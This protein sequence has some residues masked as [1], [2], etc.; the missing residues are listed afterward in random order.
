MLVLTRRAGE[1][2]LINKGEVRIKVLCERNGTVALGVQVSA[3]MNVDRKEIFT[4]KMIQAK[5]KQGF[6]DLEPVASLPS[7]FNNLNLRNKPC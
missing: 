4:K 3:H 6:K 1:Q 5:H 7:A 2:I